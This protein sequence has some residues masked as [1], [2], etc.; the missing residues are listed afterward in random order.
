MP[1]TLNP[2]DDYIAVFA[3]VSLLFI[4]FGWT[5]CKYQKWCYC[6][7]ILN[8]VSTSKPYTNWNTVIMDGCAE[9]PSL[10]QMDQYL[11]ITW[12]MTES[13]WHLPVMPIHQTCTAIHLCI[14]WYMSHVHACILNRCVNWSEC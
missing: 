6:C 11:A 8:K 14:L 3:P 10:Y 2:D 5:V 9:R 1:F 13:I 4:C 7:D 12:N